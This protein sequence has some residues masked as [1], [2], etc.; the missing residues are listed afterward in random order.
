MYIVDFE[1]GYRLISAFVEGLVILLY[2]LSQRDRRL[3]VSGR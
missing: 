3:E 1:D 2:T